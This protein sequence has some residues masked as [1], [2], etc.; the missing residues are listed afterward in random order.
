MHPM[1]NEAMTKLIVKLSVAGELDLAD[2]L[3]RHLEAREA[4]DMTKMREVWLR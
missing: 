3:H 4:G 2:R 1:S